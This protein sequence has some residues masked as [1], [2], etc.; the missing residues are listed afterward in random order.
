LKRGEGSSYFFW[1]GQGLRPPWAH[2]C[3]CVIKKGRRSFKYSYSYLGSTRPPAGNGPANN[4][5]GG[6]PPGGGKGSGRSG[7]GASGSGG[8]GSGGSGSGGSGSG[9]PCRYPETSVLP[10]LGASRV[11]RILK[12]LGVDEQKHRF[13][14]AATR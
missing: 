7:S 2:L 11:R 5:T 1:R 4:A 9:G 13:T 14:G 6:N 8:S 3:F 12:I 10:T